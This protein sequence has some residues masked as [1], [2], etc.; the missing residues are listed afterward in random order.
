MKSRISPHKT[1]KGFAFPDFIKTEKRFSRKNYG[2]WEKKDGNSRGFLLPIL[3]TIFIGILFFKLFSLQVINGSYYKNLSDN[4]RI[5]TEVIH[6]PRGIIVDRNGI[7]LVFNTPGFRKT[8]EGKTILLSREEAIS[9]IT[10]G[11][12]NLEVDTLRKYPYKDVFA[13]ILGYIGQISEEELK[14]ND[15]LDY[16]GGDLVGKM[17]IEKTYEKKLRG[18]DGKKLIEVDAM[19]KA[20][21]TLGQTE[22]VSGENISLTLDAKIQDVAYKALTDI[23]KGVVIVSTPR[24]EI[25]AMISKPA[26]DPNLFTLGKSYKTNSENY[27]SLAS[28]LADENNQP[29][30][31][32]A[33]SGTYPPGSTFKLITAVAGLENKIIDEKFQVEDIGIL[34]VGDFSFANWY[35]TDYGKTDGLVDVVIGIKRSNDIFF[36][37]LAEKIGVEKLSNMAFRFGLGKTLGIDLYGEESGIVPTND[38]KKKVIGEPWYLGDTYHYGIGQ[39]YLLTTPLQVNV[40]TQAIANG[41][42]LYKPYLLKNAKNSSKQDSALQD[43]T[44]KLSDKTISLVREGMIEAC[45]PGGAAWPLFEFKVQNSKLKIDGKNITGIASSSANT[46]HVVI[47]CKTGTAQQGGEKDLPHAWITLF[48]PAY[49]PQIVVT[50]LAEASG[51]GSNVAAPIAKKVLEEWFG[52]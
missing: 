15:F 50:V 8:K 39:G 6:A 22:A 13:H 33:I 16:K 32:R 14:S 5:R 44:Q 11:E 31:N 30:L 20:V 38:W 3:T 45:N 49:D 52:R 48:A 18:I 12:K 21:R 1:I 24:G 51:Q 40:W 7:A 35:F 19:G 34:R 26:F 9:F 4:N 25:L 10:K 42:I 37:K 47:A 27:D 23:K 17:G 36:Y 41:G 29:F 2:D 46:R 28:L 43:R